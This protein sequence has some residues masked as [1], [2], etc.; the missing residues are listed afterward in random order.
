MGLVR[1]AIATAQSVLSSF[2]KPMAHETSILSR[3]HLQALR[4]LEAIVRLKTFE[5]AARELNVTPGAVSQQIRR[6]EENLGVPLFRRHGNRSEPTEAAIQIAQSLGDAFRG[7]EVAL[8]QVVGRE[9]KAIKFRVFQ[10]WANR[11]LIPRLDAFY[12]QHPGIA[13]EFET[14]IDTVDTDRPDLDMAL[15]VRTVESAGH[16][17][18]PLFT[19]HLCPVCTP[20]VA[21]QL[22]P[23]LDLARV[24]LIASRNR[25]ADWPRW[26][27]RADRAANDQTPL[28]VFSNSTL[29][30]EAAMAGNGLAIAQ[31]ELVLNDLL[32]G[33][34]VRPFPEVIEANEPISI[35]LPTSRAHRGAPMAF[36][37]WLLSEAALLRE[38]TESYLA[39]TS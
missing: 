16:K 35:V 12:Q 28:L 29:V 10:T 38:R 6:L 18:I 26:L 39:E 2:G 15:T 13:V 36:R 8:E 33:R 3:L 9:L 20:S 37:T 27:D 17:L 21:V 7:I 1:Y 5:A 25:M 19:P 34:L 24:P 11:W 30:Y 23:T 14:G 4:H 22:G 32:A 31:V